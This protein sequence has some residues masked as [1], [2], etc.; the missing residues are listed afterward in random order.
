MGPKKK[1]AKNSLMKA[2]MKELQEESKPNID[3]ATSIFRD[4]ILGSMV[5][6]SSDLKVSQSEI[7]P[8]EGLVL[9]DKTTLLGSDNNAENKMG[10]D[11]EIESGTKSG[12]RSGHRSDSRSGNKSD[13]I[14]DS[15][16]LLELEPSAAEIKIQEEVAQASDR[17]FVVGSPKAQGVQPKVSVGVPQPNAVPGGG[18]VYDANSLQQSHVLSLAQDRIVELEKALESLRRENESLHAAVEVAQAKGSELYDRLQRAERLLSD[19]R[20][21]S[22]QELT[23]FKESLALKDLE[24]NRLKLKVQELDSRLAQDLKK[25]RVRERELENR[26]ELSRVEKAALLRAKDEHLLD[27]QRKNDALRSEHESSQLKV[28][29]LQS[30]IDTHHE[31][32]ARTI[33]ALRLA[34]TQLETNDEQTVAPLPIKKAE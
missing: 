3:S 8:P 5:S 31:Q 28:A 17:T 33:R 12:K 14:E 32:F 9:E 18:A 20:N 1:S 13:Q 15:P 19:Q 16:D 24:N 6:S 22:E 26:L 25:I 27:L 29:E 11:S 10:I 4:V 23:L 30:K 21:T 2:R 7:K 34:L